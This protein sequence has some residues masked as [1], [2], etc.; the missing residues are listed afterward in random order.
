MARSMTQTRNDKTTGELAYARAVELIFERG[1]HGTSVRDVARAVGVQMST[2]YHY[3]PSKQDLLMAIMTTAMQE[4]TE[5]VA[6]AIVGLPSAR[7]QMEAAVHAHIMFHADR[8][9]EAVVADTELRSLE[10]DDLRTILE[11]RDNYEGMFRKI[12]I[13]GQKAGE[14]RATDARLT[15]RSILGAI[16]DVG[17]WYRPKGS[18]TLNAISAEYCGVFLDGIAA[19]PDRAAPARRRAPS[20]A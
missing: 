8:L 20:G 3:Y 5:R 16:T 15:T 4:M 6:E 1:Y 9:K 10:G 17:N 13:D 12:I 14:L 2:L 11:M 18:L 19:V 7:E